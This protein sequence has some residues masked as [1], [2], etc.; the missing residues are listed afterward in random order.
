MFKLFKKRRQA[1][2]VAERP[3]PHKYR[4]K[5]RFHVGGVHIA[6]WEMN[7]NSKDKGL[8][9]KTVNAHLQEHLKH[10]IE[11]FKA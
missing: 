7:L 6:S 9:R 8:A 2:A 10:S 4:A 5:V 1:I 11:I 3:Y